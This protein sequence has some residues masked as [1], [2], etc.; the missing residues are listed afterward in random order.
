MRLARFLYAAVIALAAPFPF[1]ISSS[2]QN[3]RI[4]RSQFTDTTDHWAKLCIEGMGTEGV[5][6]GY[7]DGRFRPEGTMTRAEFAAVMIKAFPNAPQIRESPDFP[8]VAA[9]FWGREAIA[10]AYK[11]GFLTGYPDGTFKPA[12]AINRTQAIVVIANAHQ[13][14][15][16]QGAEDSKAVLRQHFDD[17]AAV[18]AYAEEAI[19]AATRSALVVNYPAVRQLRPDANITRGEATAFLCRLNAAGTDARYYVP[20][21]Y[22]ANFGQGTDADL[23]PESVLTEVTGSVSGL[24]D[25]FAILNEEMYFFINGEEEGTE[26]WVSDGTVVGTR[27]VHQPED[28]QDGLGLRFP[29]VV[30]SSEQRFWLTAKTFDENRRLNTRLLSSDGTSQGT[31]PIASLNMNLGQLLDN[32]FD[33]VTE[34]NSLFQD[35]LPFTVRI[36]E[37]SQLWIT[38]GKSESGTQQLGSFN[39]GQG[40]HLFTAADDYLFFRAGTTQ[41]DT[42]LWRSDGSPSGTIALTQTIT[43]LTIAFSQGRLYAEMLSEETGQELWTSDGSIAG[44]K[45]LKDIFPGEESSQPTLLTSLNERFWVVANTPEG[46]QLLSTQGTT[47]STQ[48]VKTLSPERSAQQD[49]SLIVHAGQLFF[50]IAVSREVQQADGSRLVQEERELWVTDGT[51][52]GTQRLAQVGVDPPEFVPF[53]DQLFFGGRGPDGQEL[54]VTD[55]TPTGTKQVLNLATG[56]ETLS[57]PPCAAPP[58]DYDPATYCQPTVVPRDAR[59]RSLTAH[60]DSLYFIADDGDLFRTDGT[61]QGIQHIRSFDGPYHDWPPNIVRLNDTLLVMGAE[62]RKLLL[63]GLSE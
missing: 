15:S 63:W 7:L 58:P 21:Q 27:A 13:L 29:E 51:A 36:D 9:D 61:G 33:L 50:N 28:T 57:P 39:A 25:T 45:L 42:G 60:G 30:A 53:K 44:T 26:I 5:M 20:D 46:L 3:L 31:V 6:K 11:R 54:W 24:L 41:A 47:E 32:A 56:I 49:R 16:S 8:D 17:A 1:A 59:V 35:R 23:K 37:G 10:Q 62:E 19:A 38:D 14:P 12:Q 52:A 43:P 40:P 2:A 22:V 55:G 34:P 48:V 4:D 18:P